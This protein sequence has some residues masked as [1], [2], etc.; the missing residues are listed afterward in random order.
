MHI[1]VIQQQVLKQTHDEHSQ[2]VALK[3]FSG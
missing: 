1:A 2:T 3:Y